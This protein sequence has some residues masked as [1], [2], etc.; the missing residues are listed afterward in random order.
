MAQAYPFYYQGKSL[1]IIAGWISIMTLIFGYLFEPF[2]V[3][4]PEHKMHYFWI[5][6]IH[7]LAPLTVIILYSFKKP[8]T[9]I[10][11]NWT[12][13]KEFLLISTFLLLVGIV[14]FLLREIIY[15]NPNNWSWGYLYEE[16]RNTFLVGSLFTFIL[17]SLNFNLLNAKHLKNATAFNNFPIQSKTIETQIDHNEIGFKI[18]ELLFAKAEGNYVNLYFTDNTK[19]LKRTTIKELENNLDH[20]ANILKTHRSYLVNTNH[21]E[22]VTGNAQGYKLE[23]KNHSKKVPVSRNMIAPFKVRMQKN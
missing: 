20:H 19:L 2:G 3:Y 9:D 1:W 7:A 11:E 12:I 8:S 5:S 23:L 4:V 6:S 22:N 15:D 16:I 21:I 18:E 13:L 17:V 14:Q 10:E